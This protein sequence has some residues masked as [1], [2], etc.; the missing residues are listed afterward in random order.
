MELQACRLSYSAVLSGWTRFRIYAESW[1]SKDLNENHDTSNGTV[2]QRRGSDLGLKLLTPIYS[3]AFLLVDAKAYGVHKSREEHEES[4]QT[5]EMPIK[6]FEAIQRSVFLAVIDLGGALHNPA[7]K[8]YE[9]TLSV[10][11]SPALLVYSNL[12]MYCNTPARIRRFI[13]PE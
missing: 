1:L 4:Q 13:T 7:H 5:R 3:G 8:S 2:R 6:R 9:Q 11:G 12:H 10:L